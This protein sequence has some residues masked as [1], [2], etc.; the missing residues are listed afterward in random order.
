M[1][2]LQIHLLIVNLQL[3][4]FLPKEENTKQSISFICNLQLSEWCLGYMLAI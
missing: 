2:D 1:A 4:T 3:V